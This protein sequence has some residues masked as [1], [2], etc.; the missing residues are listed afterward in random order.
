MPTHCEKHFILCG[1]LL[2]LIQLSWSLTQAIQPAAN[3]TEMTL[4]AMARDNQGGLA[5]RWVLSFANARKENMDFA[6][7]SVHMARAGILAIRFLSQLTK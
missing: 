2:H 1:L 6:D 3:R 7:L 5:L 4:L